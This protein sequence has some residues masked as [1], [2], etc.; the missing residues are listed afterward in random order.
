M[1]KFTNK[2]VPN[3]THGKINKFSRNTYYDSSKKHS[4]D[5]SA[6][7]HF[8]TLPTFL[9]IEL[10]SNCIDQMTFSWTLDILEKYYSL[11]AVVRCANQHFTIA[12]NKACSKRRATAVPKSN[13]IVISI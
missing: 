8:V 7:P 4:G 5:I 11:K 2:Y 12:I 10:S 1:W 13:E 6:L 3:N 9:T